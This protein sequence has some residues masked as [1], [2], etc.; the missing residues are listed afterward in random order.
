[1][2]SL[3]LRPC[4]FSSSPEQERG[5]RRKYND[6][7]HGRGNNDPGVLLAAA[8]TL[9]ST[10]CDWQGI[11]GQGRWLHGVR[12]IGHSHKCAIGC[13]EVDGLDG[14]VAVQNDVLRVG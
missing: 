9:C 13:G 8:L 10:T 5:S 1:M 4:A 3:S 6:R 2:A 7:H 14:P 11:H 12:E